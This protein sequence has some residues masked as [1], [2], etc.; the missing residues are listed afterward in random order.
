MEK[1]LASSP[2]V[3]VISSMAEKHV[4]QTRA[5]KKWEKW[6]EIP[7]V[8]HNEI[9]FINPDLIHRPG[10]RIVEGLEKLSTM[11]HPDRF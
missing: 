6:K 7:A 4:S 2:E 9:Y 5:F 10:P 3:I 11:I 8:K 1:V